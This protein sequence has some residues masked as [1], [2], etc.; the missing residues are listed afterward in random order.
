METRRYLSLQTRIA[1]VLMALATIFSGILSSIIYIDFKNELQNNLRHRLENI[2][3]L[4]SLQQNGDELLKV[5]AQGDA[6][7]NKIQERNANIKRADPDLIFV[8]TLR[9]ND[10]GI[11]FVVDA[12][13]SPDEE[14]IS[15]YG[16]PY[17]EPSETLVANF[18]TMTGT[19]V[20]PEIYTDEF[21]SFLSGYAP[22]YTSNGERAGVLGV[23]ISADTI[24]TQQRSYFLRLVFIFLAS[25]PLIFISSMVFANYLARPI[26]N[27][28]DMANK[29]SNGDFNTR[30]SDIPRTRELAELATDLNLMTENLSQLINDLETRVAERTSGLTKKTDQL[31]A[32]SYIARQTADVQDLSAILEIVVN[33]ITNQFGFYHAG[34][35]LINET[36]DE[37]VL[38]AASSEGGAR[39]V[40]RGHSLRVGSQGI[41]GYVAAQKRARIAL[42][43]GADA[44][45]FNNPD[46]PMTRS[47]VALPLLVR[48]K[49]L[50][51][52]DI[53]SDEP[54][55]FSTE[56]I[57]VL[58]TL[59]DQVA[60]A[61]ENAR[62]LSEAQAALIQL[63]AVSTIRTREAWGKKLLGQ[64]LG[65]T[66]TPLGIRAGSSPSE[67]GEDGLNS[68]ITLR[69]QNIGSISLARKDNS[70]WSKVDE[71]LINEVAYQVG[72]AV[73][74]LRLLE[75]AQ[76]RARQE[77]TIG[78]LATRF[79]QS[80]DID[81]LLQIAA[82]ELGQLPDVS[83]VSVY[84]G[85]LPEQAP[86]KRRPKRTTG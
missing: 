79:S 5:Q 77:Q 35:F 62:L 19:V 37:A 21:G 60:V 31:R 38:Q 70:E 6:A 24:N 48:N 33:L 81:S 54:Q 85:Q 4:A 59:A 84:I 28:R 64:P 7:F 15:D 1:I 18:D 2:T 42:D 80:L 41:V 22:I 72:L 46:L 17:K 27:L 76:Q 10:Q 3:T 9:K 49:T 51:V 8:Y 43:V 67:N 14:D 55:A 52:L 75:D 56:D 23:D 29:I 68:P 71:D 20:E 86:Q 13:I 11:Y 53:Q 39:M 50:G 32:A 65:F 25:L 63:E 26:V 44:V 30:I 16:D 66:Y 73:D 78:E 69:G 34:I 61:I 45:F 57:D 58:Q 83:E 36:G 12:R 47:E 74:N 40:E 82:R